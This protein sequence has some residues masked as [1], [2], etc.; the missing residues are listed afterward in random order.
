ME[1]K[2]G[3]D[4]KVFWRQLFQVY[5]NLSMNLRTQNNWIASNEPINGLK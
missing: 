3:D 2:F 4:V 5:R 1:V